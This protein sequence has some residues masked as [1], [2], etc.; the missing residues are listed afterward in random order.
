MVTQSFL[1]YYFPITF[2][3]ENIPGPSEVG[4]FGWTSLRLDQLPTPTGQL[5]LGTGRVG[6]QH[7]KHLA[8]SGRTNDVSPDHRGP[9]A[10]DSTPHAPPPDCEERHRADVV[11]SGEKVGETSNIFHFAV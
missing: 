10:H 6:S 4:R 2:I 5:H 7:R 8:R 9:H 3:Q 11:G 1:I